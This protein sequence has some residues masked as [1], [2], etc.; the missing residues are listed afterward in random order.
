MLKKKQHLLGW[1]SDYP[2][3]LAFLTVL[4]IYVRQDYAHVGS[5]RGL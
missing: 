5:R 1:A 2:M 4:K 3:S